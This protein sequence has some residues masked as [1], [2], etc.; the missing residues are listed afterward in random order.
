[1]LKNYNKE[2]QKL[3]LFGVGPYI[4]YGMAV[5]TILG[6]VLIGYVLKIGVLGKPWILVFRI[7]GAIIIIAG[8]A[9]WF[10]GAVRSDMDNHIENNKLKTDGIYA[11]VRNP[12]YS[13]W[14]MAITGITLM[15]HNIWMLVLPVMNWL[16]MSVILINTEEKWLLNLYGDE[17]AEYTK[18]V[19]RCIPW[20]PSKDKR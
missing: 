15:W 19:N 9:V 1:M 14:W 10:I 3:P 8:I 5:L 12:M 13:G 18:K 7:A 2:G 16:I 17:Y 11:W 20:K 4:V 6:I